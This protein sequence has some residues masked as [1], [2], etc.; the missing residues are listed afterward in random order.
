MIQEIAPHIYDNAFAHRRKLQ[1]EDSVLAFTEDLKNVLV[2]SNGKFPEAA[3]FSAAERERMTYLFTIDAQA[4][5]SLENLEQTAEEPEG[6]HWDSTVMFRTMRPEYLG[7][8]GVTGM[9]LVRWTRNHR[10]CGRCGTLLVPSSIE[11]AFC[12]EHC[13]N[14]VY[15]RICPGVIWQSWTKKRNVCC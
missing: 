14:I 13:G 1:P 8:A 2:D 9:Q 6:L 10:F 7:F 3:N 12:C 4:F 11:R 5:F 15:P